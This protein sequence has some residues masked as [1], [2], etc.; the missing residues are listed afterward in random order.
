MDAKVTV[1]LLDFQ[2]D[3]PRSYRYIHWAGKFQRSRYLNQMRKSKPFLDLIKSLLKRLHDRD[4]I[5]MVERVNII[6]DLYAWLPNES[7]SRFCRKEGL[8]TL[9]AKFTFATPGKCRDGIDAPWKDCV[10]AT[11]PISNMEQL[12]GRIVR[13]SENKQTPIIIDFLDYG[14]FD[15]SR[16]FYNRQRLYEKK[17]WDVQYLLVKENQIKKINRDLAME[18]L[19]EIKS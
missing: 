11:S 14:S 8:E 6:D 9:K 10:I 3:T 7:K 2:I 19:D 5:C 15:I 13:S 18:I 1:I 4:V 16:T 12:T 17:G